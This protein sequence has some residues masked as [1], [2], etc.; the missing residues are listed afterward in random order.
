MIEIIIMFGVLGNFFLQAGW[1]IWSY[2]IHNR[3]HLTDDE[4]EIELFD[5]LKKHFDDLEDERKRK[6]NWDDFSNDI[7]IPLRSKEEILQSEKKYNPDEIE[8]VLDNLF[9][10]KSDG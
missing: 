9:K 6:R 1:F 2:R 8:G 5:K 4:I 10:G 7:T 3:K